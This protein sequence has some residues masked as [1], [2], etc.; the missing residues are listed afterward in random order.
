MKE[1]TQRTMQY[2]LYKTGRMRCGSSRKENIPL[3][4]QSIIQI[5]EMTQAISKQ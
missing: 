3:R 4:S 2:K 5:S 1:S